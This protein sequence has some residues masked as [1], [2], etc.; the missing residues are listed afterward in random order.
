MKVLEN[1]FQTVRFNKKESLMKVCWLEWP[2]CDVAL[3]AEL[4][5]RSDVIRENSPELM[6]VECRGGKY[7]WAELT[8]KWNARDNWPRWEKAGMRKLAF[9]KR[10]DGYGDKEFDVAYRGRLEFSVFENQED[11]LSWLREGASSEG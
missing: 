2:Q 9:V 11:A 10:P 7:R 4:I 3:R 8:R 6:L 1:V 5:R